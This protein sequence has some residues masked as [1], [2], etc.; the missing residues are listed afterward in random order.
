MAVSSYEQDGKVFWQV[1][2]DIR[3]KKGSGLRFQRRLNGLPSERAARAKERDLIQELTA[4]ATT[5]V[6]QGLTWGAVIDRWVEQ[7]V[8]FPTKRYVRTTIE[9]YSA[10]LRNW[11]KP[12]LARMACELNRGDGR[13]IDQLAEASN[14]SASFR[15]HLKHTINLIYTWGI[16]E[17]LISGVHQSP[18][19]GMH[20]ERDRGESTP[21]ILT[22]EEIRNLLVTAKETEHAWYPVW[23]TAV[24]TGCRSGEL[25]ALRR[26]DVEEIPRDRA[27]DEEKLPPE[28]RRYGF[29]RIRRSWNARTK[30]E[31]PTK[32]GHW[33]TV[34]ISSELYW[35]MIHDLKIQTLSPEAYVLP[36]YSMWD[37]G[38]QAM[39]IRAFCLGHGLPSIKFHTLRACFATQLIASGVPSAI[40]MK[41]CGWRDLKTMQ[42]YIRLAGIDEGGATEKLRFIPSEA[43]VMEKVVGLVMGRTKGLNS[44]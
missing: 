36:R 5:R 39:V 28:R 9:D 16:E 3:G 18:V 22:T 23:V 29:I 10:L 41:I 7:Q 24:L 44:T 37:R 2:V 25:H 38:L 8:N 6:A 43:A 21:E 15:R 27:I 30:T 17:R 14:K 32:A 4:E 26:G 31:G 13:F 19:A 12:W 42:H 40:V 1:Y 20:I 11:T 33:R 34:P 35:F